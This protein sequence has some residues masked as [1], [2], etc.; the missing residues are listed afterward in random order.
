MK[1][2]YKSDFDFILRLKDCRGQDLS[3]P[4]YDWIAKFYTNNKINA[5]TAS[6]IGGECTNCFNDNGRIHVVVNNHRM[7]QGVLCVE[8]TA[9]IP[10]GVYPD[11]DERIVVP[12]PLD[13]ELVSKAGECHCGAEV[14]AILPYI[15]G[16]KGDAFTYSDFTAE[17]KMELIAPIK[18]SIDGVINSKQDALI[19]SADITLAGTQLK[20]TEAAKYEA[21]DRQWEAIGGTVVKSGAT[22]E[23]NDGT[24]TFAD[25]VKA[26]SYYSEQP[27]ANLHKLCFGKSL[28]LLPTILIPNVSLCDFSN[29]FQST[30]GLKKIRLQSTLPGGKIG[31]GNA[32]AMF[33]SSY[34]E[35]VD[36]ILDISKAD[37]VGSMFFYAG[38]MREVRLYGLKDN[39]SMERSQNI[40]LA[41]IQYAVDNAANTNAITITLHPDAYARI[42]DELFAL[43]AERQITLATT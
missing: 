9:M 20:L 32:F 11:G 17:Q 18:N 25:A 23:I 41:S 4:S 10:N 6:S 15:K 24:G 29:A 36:G 8:F 13:I 1:I 7:G 34:V 26:M 43:A 33:N 16:D 5:Y 12:A 38:R 40:S 27:R 35:E 30:Y 2:N 21:F 28:S 37:N 3:F 14:E 42:T 39:L 19:D 31:V 22:Y